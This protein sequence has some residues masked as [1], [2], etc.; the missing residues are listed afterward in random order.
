VKI[1]GCCFLVLSLYRYVT[2]VYRNGGGPCSSCLPAW[3]VEVHISGRGRV[4][5]IS[6]LET[7]LSAGSLVG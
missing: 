3:T 7:L 6:N 4:F 5:L 1:P 2:E